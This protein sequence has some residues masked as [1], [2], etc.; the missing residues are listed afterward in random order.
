MSTRI[1]LA[2]L[3]DVQTLAA[4]VDGFAQ[5]HP[6]AK[7][8]RSIEAMTE[9]YLGPEAISRV[10]LAE[11]DRTAFAF[12]AWRK[13]YDPYWSYFGGEVMALYVEPAWRGHGVALSLVAAIA[14]EIRA[15]GG[16]FL[17]GNYGDTVAPLY[18]RL[19]TGR[20]ERACHVSAERFETIAAAAGRSPREILKR[21][22]ET[23][24]QFR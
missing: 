4:L 13:T 7:H 17:Q 23:G 24:Q 15:Y 20:D 6:G 19:V 14:A 8:P 22:R 1:R 10:L 12:G 11:R 3:R 2:T 18:E 5:N 9:A 16:H 21:W